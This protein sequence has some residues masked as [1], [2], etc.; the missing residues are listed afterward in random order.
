[1]L[2]AH[3]CGHLSA[4]VLGRINGRLRF[5]EAEALLEADVVHHYE[6][7][8]EDVVVWGAAV[9]LVPLIVVVWTLQEV[10]EAVLLVV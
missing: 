9:S 8:R 2:V 4:W 7:L 6:C 3:L 10:A 1:M 5:L